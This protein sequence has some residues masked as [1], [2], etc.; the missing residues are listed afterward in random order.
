MFC[1]Y[2]AR[3]LEESSSCEATSFLN[4]HLVQTVSDDNKAIEANG[5]QFKIEMPNTLNQFAIRNFPKR[6][7]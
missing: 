6:D 3:A 5:V 7:M 2:E 4:I 1:F